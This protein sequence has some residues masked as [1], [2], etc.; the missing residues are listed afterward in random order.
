[1]NGAAL[2]LHLMRIE[3]TLAEPLQSSNKT[4]VVPAGPVFRS[5]IAI[6][7]SSRA[8]AVVQHLWVRGPMII[9]NFTF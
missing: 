4:L 5:S 6:C 3:V 2:G 7:H 1:M 8:A 9:A